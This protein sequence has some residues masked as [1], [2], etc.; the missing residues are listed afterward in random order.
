M[1][2]RAWHNY[3]DVRGLSRARLPRLF[4]E[5]V[6]GGGYDEGTLARN[7]SDFDNLLIRHQVMVDVGKVD[8]G[9][10]LLGH[11]CALPLVLAPIGLGGMVRRRAE[12]P[13][14]RAAAAAG[15]PLC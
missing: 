7:R 15:V 3:D 1:A 10:Q 6:E 4:Y 5:F 14:A 9:A 13:A 11:A 12:A 2:V 8:T